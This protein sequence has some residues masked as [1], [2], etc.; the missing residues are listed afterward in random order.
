MDALVFVCAIYLKCISKRYC[1][2]STNNC[3]LPLATFS[4]LFN[5]SIE[6]TT[7]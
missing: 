4:A 6:N 7:K 3:F 5:F 2:A 1:Y